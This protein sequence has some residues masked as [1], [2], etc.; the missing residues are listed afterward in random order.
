MKNDS[1]Q[2]RRGGKLVE[3]ASN[4]RLSSLLDS[5]AAQTGMRVGQADSDASVAAMSEAALFDRLRLLAGASNPHDRMARVAASCQEVLDL[6]KP[7]SKRSGG[8]LPADASSFTAMDQE[9]VAK[10]TRAQTSLVKLHRELAEALPALYKLLVLPR[11]HGHGHGHG[12]A[13]D[14]YGLGAGQMV[15][16]SFRP[17]SPEA[18]RDGATPTAPVPASLRDRLLRLVREQLATLE[19]L[20]SQVVD[21]VGPAPTALWRS[22]LAVSR[23]KEP[24]LRTKHQ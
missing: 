8:L 9:A 5:W 14:A 12:G 3:V 15:S 17:H 21:A 20:G 10:L 11:G 7:S 24:E 6:R 19:G 23:E 1:V 16:A 4:E 18:R 13:A 22:Y 2:A